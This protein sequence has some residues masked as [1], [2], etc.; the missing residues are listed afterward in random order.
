MQKSP[1]DRIQKR[2]EI[3]TD[4]LAVTFRMSKIWNLPPEIPRIASLTT[5]VFAETCHGDACVWRLLR[6]YVALSLQLSHIP[7]R[8]LSKQLPSTMTKWLRRFWRTE[9]GAVR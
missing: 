3:S 8:A 6:A 4:D 1:F 9:K 5:L 7:D 2:N